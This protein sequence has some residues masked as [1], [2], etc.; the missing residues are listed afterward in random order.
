MTLAEALAE[1]VDS[2][3]RTRERLRAVDDS[4]EHVVDEPEAE[5]VL[6]RALAALSSVEGYEQA[7]R[8]AAGVHV[9]G[10]Y[11]LAKA[12]LVIWEPGS[13]TVRP[14]ALL[15]E[16]MKVFEPAVREARGRR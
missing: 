16:L 6:R 14:A 5:A 2:L 3:A 8:V 12:G 9:T 11:D 13:D 7:R 4:T 1:R 15:I 10:C